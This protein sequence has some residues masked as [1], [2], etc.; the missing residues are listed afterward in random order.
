MRG[1]KVPA[2]LLAVSAAMLLT[3][4]GGG[5]APTA[6]GAWIRL[7]AVAG[8]PAAAYVTIG[9]GRDAVELRTVRVPAA[10]RVELH[11][12]RNAGGVMSMTPVDAIEVPAGGSA[13]LAPGGAHAMLFDLDPALKA[14]G[15]TKMT[16]VFDKAPPIELDARLAAPG[17]TG[18]E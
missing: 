17:A 16:L 1:S 10:R 12:T 9:G 7:P 2:G 15:T 3:A 8:R 5:E 14:G 13:A 11:E 4:C 6:Q 18:P